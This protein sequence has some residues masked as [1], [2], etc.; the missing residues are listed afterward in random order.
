MDLVLDFERPLVELSRRIASLRLI[1][2]AQ[3]R[4]LGASIRQLEEQSERLQ[5]QI[6][7]ALSPWQRTLLS[8]HPARPYTLDYT[9]AWLQDA[10]ELHGDRAR[11]DDDPS[12][13]T[14]GGSARR[15]MTKSGS[16]RRSPGPVAGGPP[17]E[18]SDPTGAWRA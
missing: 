15:P 14:A 6:F 4:D 3:G 17:C 16:A 10:V 2:A 13:I 12:I 9:S 5:R 18:L 7:A 11:E 1:E 8:R